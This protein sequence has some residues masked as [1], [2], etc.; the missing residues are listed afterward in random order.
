[1]EPTPEDVGRAV[2]DLLVKNCMTRRVAV[3][4]ATDTLA[5]ASQLMLWRRIR[6][7]PVLNAEDEVVGL[8]SD[9]DLLR[10]V[11]AGPAGS[12]PVSEVIAPTVHVV[13]ELATVSQ[14]AADLVEYGV[15]ALAVV[16]DMKHLIGIVSTTDILGEVGRNRRIKEG[17]S[18]RDLMRVDVVHTRPN[19]LL[20]VAIEKMLEAHVRHLPVVDDDFRVVGILSDRD[21]RTAAGDPSR[22]VN[23]VGHLAEVTVA[24]IMTHSPITVNAS[25]STLE[26]AD[27]FFERRVG[28]IPI[29]RDDD[30]LV[31]IVSY[32]D[33]I[34][35][36]IGRDHG[37]P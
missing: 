19:E 11:V 18:V 26:I 22:A 13:S 34:G 28:A 32:V 15:D 37:P 3:V 2:G 27:I 8:L 7:L 30:T 4:R 23:Q 12:R 20:T 16:D 35:H 6:H 24:R 1:M 21:I 17:S 10:H 25:M 9:R 31:G 14:A 5:Y 29:V 36:L 33:V